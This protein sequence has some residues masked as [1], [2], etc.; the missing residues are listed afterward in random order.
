LFL[1]LK[2]H[3]LFLLLAAEAVV[4]H[5]AGNRFKYNSLKYAAHTLFG[6]VALWLFIRLEDQAGELP[7]F[8]PKALSDLGVMAMAA[9]VS[10]RFTSARARNVYLFA[11]HIALLMLTYREL[12][13]LEHGLAFISLAWGVYA[14]GIL[15]AGLQMRN[16]L[17]RQAGLGTLLLVVA[18]LFLMDL[19]TVD[20]IWRILLF[21]GF[22]GILLLLSYFFRPLW[23]SAE[24]ETL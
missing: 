10:L 14:I 2:G 20:A 17:V 22:G 13:V 4:L 9:I 6:I 7:F 16:T 21:L 3:W 23:K 1:V 8:N 11:A 18:K 5:L 19:A 15:I 24:A 12:A